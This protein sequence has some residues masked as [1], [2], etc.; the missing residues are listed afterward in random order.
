MRH[1]PGG[2]LGASVH[3]Q[4]AVHRSAFI[5]VFIDHLNVSDGTVHVIHIVLKVSEQNSSAYLFIYLLKS[6]RE[7]LR[8]F[9]S[10]QVVK[11]CNIQ[12]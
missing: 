3:L 9:S 12:S 2:G 6:C 7:V 8:R 5:F 10:D 4:Q 11:N 1:V